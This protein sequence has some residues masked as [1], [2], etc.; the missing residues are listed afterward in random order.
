MK[1][2]V[3]FFSHRKY[4]EFHFDLF[5]FFA[6]ILQLKLP[7]VDCRAREEEALNWYGEKVEYN[8]LWILIK[9]KDVNLVFVDGRWSK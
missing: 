2:F 8:V 3:I 4:R 5:L 9:M 1:D 7:T 6:E